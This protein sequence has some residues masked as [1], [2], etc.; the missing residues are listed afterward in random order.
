MKRTATLVVA[1][2]PLFAFA[3]FVAC[4]SST[5]GPTCS[6]YSPPS[7]T[8]LQNPKVSFKTDVL[9]VFQQSC[10]FSDCHADRGDPRRAFLG[11]PKTTGLPTD[12]TEVYN[13]IVNKAP[14]DLPTMKYIAPG[15]PTNSFLMHKMDGDQCLFDSKCDGGTCGTSMPKDNPVLDESTRLV[16][17]RWITQGA[18]NN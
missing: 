4:S 15:D 17:Y 8:D 10:A 11:E 3:A 6:A 16:V 7:G 9:P 13:G 18:P 1:S 12:P 5:P 2:F 14:Q